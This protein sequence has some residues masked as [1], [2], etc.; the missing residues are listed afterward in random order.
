LGLETRLTRPNDQAGWYNENYLHASFLVKRGLQFGGFL[1]VVLRSKEN[2]VVL[3]L[4]NALAYAD[5][6]IP[7]HSKDLRLATGLQ[8]EFPSSTPPD[9]GDSHL[10]RPYLRMNLQRQHWI[11]SARAGWGS[12]FKNDDHHHEPQGSSFSINPHSASELLLS[13]DLSRIRPVSVGSL[14]QT[15]GLNIIQELVAHQQQ[16]ATGMLASTIQWGRLQLKGQ[17]EVPLTTARRFD[18][19]AGLAVTFRAGPRPHHH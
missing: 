1:P 15:V 10:L 19:R 12:T 14:Q 4:G 3:G 5:W 7:W 17:V 11:A 9:M 18:W 16:L 2:Q 6:R 8:L 13:G